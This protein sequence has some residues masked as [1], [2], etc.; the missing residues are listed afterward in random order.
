MAT[1]FVQNYVNQL[2]AEQS[3]EEERRGAAA[4]AGAA[5]LA[6]AGIAADRKATGL[7]KDKDAARTTRDVTRARASG[8]ADQ[9]RDA[10]KGSRIPDSGVDFMGNKNPTFSGKGPYSPQSYFDDPNIPDYDK[11]RTTSQRDA[12]QN[13]FNKFSDENAL[14]SQGLR[15]TGVGYERIEKSRLDMDAGRRQ[16]DD[17]FRRK[18]GGEFERG[19][20]FD[21]FETG[22]DRERVSK[23][24]DQYRD[25]IRNA[26]DTPDVAAARAAAGKADDAAARAAKTASAAAKKAGD[27]GT[28][29]RVAGPIGAGL[30]IP[31]NYMQ[32][33]EYGKALVDTGDRT[34]KLEQEAGH[35]GQ[36]VKPSPFSPYNKDSIGT[37]AKDA[38]SAAWQ[39]TKQNVTDTV[40]DYAMGG[41]LAD[42]GMPLLRA[43]GRQFGA[44]DDALMKDR[45]TDLDNTVKTDSPDGP[46][47]RA[48]RR[49]LVAQRTGDVAQRQARAHS[50]RRNAPELEKRAGARRKPSYLQSPPI[51]S[52]QF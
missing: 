24:G 35:R 17:R 7:F 26:P 16:G 13:L 10:T 21:K 25:A 32:G 5:G 8:A 23:M 27:T 48:E 14:D 45:V 51:S 4:G 2:L 22:P 11:P 50:R 34:S 37:K 9:L 29:L 20:K 12:M 41:G 52:M 44:V 6:G 33:R 31:F 30:S 3:E 43:L 42:P 40:K 36:E 49:A 38:A 28:L 1:R 39:G 15:R 19:P 47:T 18:F 46:L